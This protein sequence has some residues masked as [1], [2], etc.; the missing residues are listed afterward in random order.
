MHGPHT[1][2]NQTAP[3]VVPQL[4]DESLHAQYMPACLDSGAIGFTE[5]DRVGPGDGDANE[6]AK[7]AAQ[8][9]TEDNVGDV[10]DQKAPRT[11]DKGVQKTSREA[12]EGAWEGHDV[13]ELTVQSQPILT[14]RRLSP[15]HVS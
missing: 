2:Y 1:V 14:P 8:H 7:D 11:V 9:L 15:E 5:A 3:G 10:R 4:Q 13:H 6:D 12:A